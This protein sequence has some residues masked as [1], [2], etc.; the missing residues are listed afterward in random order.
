MN[1]DDWA[2]D[3][4]RFATTDLHPEVAATA[5]GVPTPKTRGERRFG[6]NGA[7]QTN[8]P[9]RRQAGMPPITITSNTDNLQKLPNVNDRGEYKTEVCRDCHVCRG[10]A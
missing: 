7:M 2:G 4:L 8:G 6:M 5:N 10:M 1:D 9:A 3:D